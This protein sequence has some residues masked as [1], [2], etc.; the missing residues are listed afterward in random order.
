M[1]DLWDFIVERPDYVPGAARFEL[2]KE[3]LFQ[4]YRK[5]FTN[6]PPS[7][8]GLS[9]EAV[10]SK[11]IKGEVA[12]D[13]KISLNP[14]TGVLSYERIASAE[15]LERQVEIA[16]SAVEATLKSRLFNLDGFRFQRAMTEV[17]RNLPWVRDVKETKLTGDG[18][19][20]FRALFQHEAFGELRAVGQ[21]KRTSSK[22]TGP[23]VREFI[24]GAL[25][26]KPKPDVGV[27]ISFSGYTTDAVAAIEDSPIRIQRYTV[28]DVI[29]WQRKYSI[30]VSKREFELFSLDQNF[31]V[32]I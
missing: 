6:A 21:V 23:E 30:G 14:F 19:I 32:E 7:E 20:D 28:E 2:S 16:N 8:P 18:G 13:W 31:W 10:E 15:S 9:F 29:A 12:G 24:G 11:L 3:A 25:S 4:E 26:S 5:R 1:A 22:T 27:F 17:L